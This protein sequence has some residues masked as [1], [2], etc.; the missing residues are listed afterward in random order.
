[1]YVSRSAA[2]FDRTKLMRGSTIT[3]T[4]LCRAHSPFC[5][6][7]FTEYHNDIRGWTITSAWTWYR[8]YEQVSYEVEIYSQKAWRN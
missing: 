2:W 7:E 3:F 1:M 5:R 4:A 8:D 6:I